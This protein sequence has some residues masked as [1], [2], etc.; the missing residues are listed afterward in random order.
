MHCT[1]VFVNIVL[2]NQESINLENNVKNTNSQSIEWTAWQRFYA[3]VLKRALDLFFGI[4][5]FII[6]L[7]ILIVMPVIIRLESKGKAIFSQ[8]R[9]GQNGKPFTMY[10]YRSMVVGAEKIGTGVYSY[11]DDNRVTKVG[12]FIRKTSIDEI[13]QVMNIIKG[14]M[15]FVG[16][17]PTLTYHP[18]PYKDYTSFQKQRFM[19]KPGITGLAQTE[20]RKAIEWT[21]RIEFDVEYIKK[22][23][24][25]QDVKMIFLTAFRI[26]KSEDN[27]NVSDTAK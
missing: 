13:P 17:R 11:K 2:E 21:K 16:P 19:V 22:I 9:L 1:G 4:L 8:T 5:F 18:W 6:A 10:K 3:K 15:S 12:R 27:V 26:L 24:L 14:E 20:G 23:G 7:P 25:F